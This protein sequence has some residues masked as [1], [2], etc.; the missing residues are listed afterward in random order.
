METSLIKAVIID[1]EIDGRNIVSYL[2]NR[3]F[4]DIEIIG[5][6]ENVAEGAAL[7]RTRLPDMV[8][9]D[10]EMPDGNA[11]DLLSECTN[12]SGDVILITAHDH[13]AIRAIKA[14]VLDYVLK[15]IDEEDFVHAVDVAL[16]KRENSHPA[17]STNLL[18]D[19]Y[20]HL[21]IRK[22]RIPT[23]SGFSL[24][25]IDDIIRCE[26]SGN[27]TNLF[28]TSR[29]QIIAC[30]KLGEYEEELKEYGFVRIHKKHLVNINQIIEYNKG[31]KGGGYVTLY[32][33]EVLEVS[34]RRKG[35]LFNILK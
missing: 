34:A 19:V 32:G 18:L 2:L 20:K 12:W 9:L 23:L 31:G 22:V 33:R 16:K 30:R 21:M 29:K 17:N 15:P 28:C 14:A 3:F 35:Y 1:D 11:F 13:Y 4:P 10:V 26:A 8:F 7:I 27:Y 25:P 6:A 24:I 5:L